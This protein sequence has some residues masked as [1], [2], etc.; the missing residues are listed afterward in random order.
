MSRLLHLVQPGGAWL[1]CGPGKFNPRC[2]KCDSLPING[3]LYRLHIIRC[4]TIIASAFWRVNIPFCR[5]STWWVSGGACQPC[6]TSTASAYT[7]FL[8]ALSRRTADRRTLSRATCTAFGCEPSWWV[9][10]E[11]KQTREAAIQSSADPEIQIPLPS[12][13]LTPCSCP[14]SLQKNPATAVP[15]TL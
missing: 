7:V 15:K 13:P 10:C 6:R 3:Q 1:G 14:L 2:T 5:R 9:S 4:G 8:V 12:P 11:E